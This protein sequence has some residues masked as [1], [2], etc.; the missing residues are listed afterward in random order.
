MRD[1]VFLYLESQKDAAT[2]LSLFKQTLTTDIVGTH[3][4]SID[5][6]I[7]WCK[8]V[9][10]HILLAH[11]QGMQQSQEELDACLYSLLKEHKLMYTLKHKA[12][13]EIWKMGLLPCEC[14]SLERGE[15]RIANWIQESRRIF[16][17]NKATLPSIRTSICGFF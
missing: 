4:H 14:S 6:F 8:H 1:K 5:T 15:R 2:N 12:K 9:A 10:K 16:T 11:K 17:L 7:C 3:F 13:Q